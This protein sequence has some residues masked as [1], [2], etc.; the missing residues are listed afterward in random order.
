[1]SNNG[2]GAPGP[3]N[4]GAMSNSSH[5]N[6]RN[7]SPPPPPLLQAGIITKVAP[8][9]GGTMGQGLG[10]IGR[11]SG[12]A[13]SSEANSTS[14]YSNNTTANLSNSR[15]LLQG[16]DNKLM[17]QQQN[18]QTVGKVMPPIIKSIDNAIVYGSHTSTFQQ[19]DQ[20]HSTA[21]IRNSSYQ[22]PN[23]N[24]STVNKINQINKKN[25][26]NNHNHNMSAQ[27][28]PLITQTN[29][30]AAAAATNSIK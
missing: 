20:Q 22:L 21:N 12:V 8:S 23:D 3:V 6:N 14:F 1:M 13:S 19:P 11:I 15:Y 27:I 18:M 30:N 10:M 28:T 29:T 26:S 7:I 9:S 2:N 17:G 16:R 5:Y 25:N 24:Q 4:F